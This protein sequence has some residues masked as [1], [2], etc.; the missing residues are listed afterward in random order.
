MNTEKFQLHEPVHI[1]SEGV[2]GII[3]RFPPYSEAVK[4]FEGEGKNG[5]IQVM[6]LTENGL[7]DSVLTCTPDEI[8]SRE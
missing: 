1:T 6:T 5:E 2:D 4:M 8:E 7:Y 3:Y